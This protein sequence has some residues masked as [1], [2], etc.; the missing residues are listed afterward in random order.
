MPSMPLPQPQ[1]GQRAARLH[2]AADSRGTV[3]RSQRVQ[4]LKQGKKRPAQT[5]HVAPVGPDIRRREKRVVN[6]VWYIG[7][8]N[9]RD[10]ALERTSSCLRRR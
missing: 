4:F 10:G 3:P 5:C 8:V 1:P 9:A 7:T 2:G 6:R